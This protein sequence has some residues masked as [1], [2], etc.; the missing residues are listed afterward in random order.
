VLCVQAK[1]TES[2]VYEPISD[3]DMEDAEMGEARVQ[4]R[5][6]GKRGKGEAS[7]LLQGSSCPGGWG[8]QG[9]R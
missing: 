2:G 1:G 9:G 5:Q 3:E 4:A 8:C 6:R 7:A